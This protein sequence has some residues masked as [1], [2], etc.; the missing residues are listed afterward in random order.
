MRIICKR[1]F[2][3][4]WKLFYLASIKCGVKWNDDSENYIKYARTKREK[5]E[6]I[7]QN[8]VNRTKN[9]NHNLNKLSDKMKETYSI[10]TA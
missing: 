9:S 3:S 6:N 2:F 5:T 8:C 1:D 10:T 7:Q 4:V